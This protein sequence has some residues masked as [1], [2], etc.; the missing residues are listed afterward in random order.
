MFFI[1]MKYKK[2]NNFSSETHNW[3]RSWQRCGRETGNTR[4]QHKYST[5]S[6][7]QSSAARRP[8]TCT[9]TF[10]TSLL[11]MLT[12]RSGPPAR[13]RAKQIT[14]SLAIKSCRLLAWPCSRTPPKPGPTFEADSDESPPLSL[15]P[16]S[17]RKAGWT[18]FLAGSLG[19]LFIIH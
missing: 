10:F 6:S 8:H 7:D 16:V 3:D 19:F 18:S 11:G 9:Q 15:S 5:Q 2:N 12:K 4:E 1:V 14:L 13:T 17:S